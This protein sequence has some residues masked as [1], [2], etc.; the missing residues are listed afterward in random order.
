MESSHV[1]TPKWTLIYN[2]KN[3]AGDLSPFTESVSFTDHLSGEAD[4][5]EIVLDEDQFTRH[6][7]WLPQK[8][9]TISVSFGYLD[10]PLVPGGTFQIDELE[11]SGPPDTVT[12]RGIAALIK[13]DLRTIR[14][15]AYEHTTLAGIAA[16][17]AKR[18]GLSIVGTVP[19]ITIDRATQHR[20][21]DLGF[22][23]QLAEKWGLVF[24]VRGNQLIWYDQEVLDGKPAAVTIIRKGLAGDY[25]IRTKHARVYRAVRAT[26]FNAKLKKDVTRSLA[27]NKV[28][29]GDT[30][31]LVQRYESLAQAK[32]A[33]WAAIRRAN[34]R[35][36]EG[37]MTVWGDPRLVSGVNIQLSGWGVMDN[38]YQIVKTTHRIERGRG[39]TTTFDFGLNGAF[40]MKALKGVK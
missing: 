14:S 11:F 16:K 24:T 12:V 38:T 26:Y 40:G 31:T 22:L 17:V 13:P 33:A 2:G 23:H 27:L 35:Q 25:R 4:D 21:T 34:G 37:D 30:L 9:D 32:R 18:H 6:G 19:P 15:A 36:T 5:M 20:E 39:Y 28:I 29:G 7:A 1:K 3:I 8:G 10:G